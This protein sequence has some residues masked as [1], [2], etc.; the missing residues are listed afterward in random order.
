LGAGSLDGA[1]LGSVEP[2]AVLEPL[3][4]VLDIDEDGDELCGVVLGSVA[5]APGA[6]DGACV[7]SAAG[8]PCVEVELLSVVCAYAKLI[9]P[10]IVAAATAVVKVFEAV[11][12]I[13]L[14]GQ[15]P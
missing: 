15:S 5:V 14:S 1:L 10:T 4:G 7:C 3:D 8:A 12:S 13:L 2:G 11:I 6:A 9:A